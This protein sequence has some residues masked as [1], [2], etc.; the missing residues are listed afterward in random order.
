L[1]REI[2][3]E[4]YRRLL[5]L[6]KTA[7][8]LVDALREAV[9]VGLLAATGTLAVCLPARI[10]TRIGSAAVRACDEQGY[11]QGSNNEDHDSHVQ[12]PFAVAERLCSP[13]CSF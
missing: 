4:R 13:V 11:K 12:P 6:R 5:T 8:L 3:A 9:R 1:S 10:G 2:A 7:F